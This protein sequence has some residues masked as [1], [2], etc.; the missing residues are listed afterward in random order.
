MKRLTTLF[1]DLYRQYGAD[2]PLPEQ[3]V[4]AVW[5]EIVGGPL[6]RR[7]RPV[8]ISRSKLVVLVP[9]ST[10]KQQLSALRGEI[11]RRLNQLLGI[12]IVRVEFRIDST[13]EQAPRELTP[14]PPKKISTP[15]ELPLQG[16]ADE[17]L[18]DRI[19]AAATAC[20]N[21]CK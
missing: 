6:A 1:S 4:A 9:S 18:R 13:V 19:Q 21:R 11:V 5:T 17:E 7:T 8:K 20:L 2:D 15:V 10:W 14:A 3:V 16:I 12:D